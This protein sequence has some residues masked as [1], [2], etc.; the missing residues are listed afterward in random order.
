MDFLGSAGEV[1]MARGSFESPQGG[2][3]GKSSQIRHDVSEINKTLQNISFRQA[4][5]KH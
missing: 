5:G 4:A 2:Q 3:V 1:L